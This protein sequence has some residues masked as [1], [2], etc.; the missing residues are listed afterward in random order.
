MTLAQ[1]QSW[2]RS[3]IAGVGGTPTQAKVDAVVAWQ[4]AEGGP[5][6]NPLNTTL[7]QGGAQGSAIKGYGSVAA[8]VTA[9][10]NTLLGGSYGPLVSLLKGNG[11]TS[12]IKTAVIQSPWDGSNH[13][14]GTTFGAG[15]APST[16]TTSTSAS[17]SSSGLPAA[18]NVQPGF[19]KKLGLT[20]ALMIG[21]MAF[22]FFGAGGPQKVQ[23]ARKID[24]MAAEG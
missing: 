18:L 7:G 19:W 12:A 9:T 14:A 23:K 22:I 10:I 2:A 20:V 16:P 3:V 13:S 11:S 17:S 24:A 21:A 5:A 4:N 8:G 15:G 1:Q 6:D